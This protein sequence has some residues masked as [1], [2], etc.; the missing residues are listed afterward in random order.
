MPLNIVKAADFVLSLKMHRIYGVLHGVHGVKDRK[1]NTHVPDPV[2]LKVVVQSTQDQRIIHGLITTRQITDVRLAAAQRHIQ[3][4]VG[5]IVE[6][7]HT[8]ERA[9]PAAAQELRPTLAMQTVLCLI[10]Q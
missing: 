3:V 2:R 6:T 1:L 4:G 10:R 5:V 7:E 8:G 9:R